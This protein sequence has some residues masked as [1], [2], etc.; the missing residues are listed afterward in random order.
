MYIMIVLEGKD[1]LARIRR[2]TKLELERI[3]SNWTA[4][5]KA[6]GEDVPT[7]II[8]EWGD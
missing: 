1:E 4:N 7:F 8:K 3:R 6:D 2:D 5:C